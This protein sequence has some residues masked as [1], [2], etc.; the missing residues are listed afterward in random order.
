V[1]SINPEPWPDGL[2]GAGVKWLDHV[3]L[4]CNSSPG[5]S[6][7]KVAENS[8]FFIEVL[9]FFQTEQIMVGPDGAFQFG[10]FMSCSGRP[11]DI[12]FAAGRTEGLHHVGF[13]LDSWQ[14]L[15]KAGDVMGKQRVRVDIGPTRHGVTRGETLYFFDPS[16]NRIETYA[17]LG[18]LAQRDR[19]VVNWTEDEAERGIFYHYGNVPESFAKSYT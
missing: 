12:A 4:V 17:G 3:A 16:G 15:L 8:K 9:D 18:Y 14:D 1:G 11:H 10:S 5:K 13:Y 6:I 7:N 19:P 2:K